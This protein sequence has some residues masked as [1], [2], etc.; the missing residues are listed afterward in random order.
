[1]PHVRL[2]EEWYRRVWQE[3]DLDAIGDFFGDDASE[4]GLVADFTIAPAEF[5][6]LIEAILDLVEDTRFE[7]VPICDCG[8]WLTALVKTHAISTATGDEVA[9][10]G[11]VA[12]RFRDGKFIEAV[13]SFDFLKFFGDLGLLPEDT[14]MTCLTGARI[15]CSTCSQT[16]SRR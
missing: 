11:L 9:A 4:E 14:L 10:N 12:V 2:L 3:G 1:M 16:S 5:R 8:E 6:D 15:A 7:V 13:N